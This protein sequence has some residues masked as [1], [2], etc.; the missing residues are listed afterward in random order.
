MGPFSTARI[1]TRGKVNE[2]FEVLTNAFATGYDALNEGLLTRDSRH[3]TPTTRPLV[4]R[5]F[6]QLKA[7]TRKY[8]PSKLPE[9]ERIE[10][11]TLSNMDGRLS[12]QQALSAMKEVTFRNG[13]S[14]QLIMTAQMRIDAAERMAPRP[15]SPVRAMRPGKIAGFSG[16]RSPFMVKPPARPASRQIKIPKIFSVPKASARPPPTAPRRL[17]VP[18]PVPIRPPATHA[19]R[20]ARPFVPKM[21]REAS[22]AMASLFGPPPRQPKHSRR[23]R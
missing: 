5:R 2:D 20:K 7:M 13:A 11:I 16:R 23:R 1:P 22:R 9:I 8:C 10:R 12:D 3:M 21:E 14:P 19:P 18:A 6:S 15:P 4:I 17:F